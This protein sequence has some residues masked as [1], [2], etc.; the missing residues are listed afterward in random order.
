MNYPIYF[1]NEDN[2]EMCKVVSAEK[3]IFVR[4]RHK[5]AGAYDYTI[6]QRKINEEDLNFNFQYFPL[7][8][9]SD[10]FFSMLQKYVEF[11]LKIQTKIT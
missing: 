7:A 1:K 5:V 8:A 10:E 2:T 6:E 11:A 9:T 3:Q 4:C